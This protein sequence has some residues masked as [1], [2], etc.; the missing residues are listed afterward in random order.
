MRRVVVTGIGMVSPLGLSV[1][2]T[3]PRL[4][5]GKSG[6]GVI[7][8]FDV[9]DLP[10]KIAGTVN[11]VGEPPSTPYEAFDPAQWLAD[12]Q[13]ATVEWAAVDEYGRV[14]PADLRERIE[15]APET[16][17]LI[18]LMWANNEVG[19]V[20]PVAEVA[21]IA[22]EHGIAVHTDAVQ[23]IGQLPV[24]FADGRQIEVGSGADERENGAVVGSVSVVRV[25]GVLAV[26]VD[27]ASHDGGNDQRAHSTTRREMIRHDS[28]LSFAT[29]TNDPGP[30]TSHWLGP[31]SWRP[32]AVPMAVTWSTGFSVTTNASR[33]SSLMQVSSIC[34]VWRVRP[35]NCGF[36]FGSFAVCR[37]I[38]LKCI[39]GGLPVTTHRSLR[40]Q[41]W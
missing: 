38:I 32:P 36:R 28:P 34:V 1:A 31:W 33:L 9:S 19:T 14:D 26:R 24:D 18:S 21:A 41:R 7:N 10:C 3:W 2:T 16:V 12:H 25:P 15:S 5:E 22:A 40:R 6:I 11:K 29:P 13:G 37:R 30:P 17:A 4:L 23:A 39:S 27:G 20:Q 35:R 8:R